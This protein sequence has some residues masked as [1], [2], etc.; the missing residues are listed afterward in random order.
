MTYIYDILLNFSEEYYDFYD[1]NKNDKIIHIKKIPVYKVDNKTLKDIIYNKVKLKLSFLNLI[2]DKTEVFYKHEIGKIKYGCL[3][4]N[5]EKMLAIN[6]STDGKIIGFSDLLIDEYTEI[7]ETL[8]EIKYIKIDYELG[9]KN[10][11]D[12]FKTRNYKIKE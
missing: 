1:W 6:V 5:A 8:D 4:Y 7:L 11:V 12:D 2:K 3:L 10:S 9:E